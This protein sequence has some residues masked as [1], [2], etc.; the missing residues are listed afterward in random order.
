MKTH[1]FAEHTFP[2]QTSFSNGT[3]M[4]VFHSLPCT[5]VHSLIIIHSRIMCTSACVYI[6]IMFIVL[7][8]I[9]ISKHNGNKLTFNPCSLPF[10]LHI[11][12]IKPTTKNWMKESH[13]YVHV[14]LMCSKSLDP[15]SSLLLFSGLHFWTSE[16]RGGGWERCQSENK[17]GRTVTRKLNV[18]FV[19]VQKH[20]AHR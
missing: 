14:G 19:H 4:W 7:L 5:I 12:L 10:T 18:L 8:S 2:G 9:L 20:D 11:S 1:L 16:V 3:K 13:F 6:F 15:L 17:D